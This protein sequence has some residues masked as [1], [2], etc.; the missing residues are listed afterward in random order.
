MKPEG[1]TADASRGFAAGLAN[2]GSNQRELEAAAAD[3]A[4]LKLQQRPVKAGGCSTSRAKGS[5]SG[6]SRQLIAGLAGGGVVRR[7][8]DGS[9]SVDRK[10]ATLDASRGLATGRAER[11]HADPSRGSRPTVEPECGAVGASRKF[12]AGAARGG[13]G[14]ESC[15]VRRWGSRGM[16]YRLYYRLIKI[17]APGTSVS[18]VFNLGPFSLLID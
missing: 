12:R 3:G 13:S 2:G 1:G 5:I 6:V 14:S 11:N 16:Q 18:G 9:P 10:R 17:E 8:P 15:R 7:K 4:S